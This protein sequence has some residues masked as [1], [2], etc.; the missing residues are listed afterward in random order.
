MSV[1]ARLALGYLIPQPDRRTAFAPTAVAVTSAAAAA[2]RAPLNVPPPKP[3][4]FRGRAKGV[5]NRKTI[6]KQDAA[7]KGQV[8]LLQ[9]YDRKILPKA[10][11]QA[12]PSLLTLVTTPF[13]AGT[14]VVARSDGIIEVSLRGLP[15]KAFL[16]QS[17]VKF[18][19]PYGCAFID[20][21]RPDKSVRVSLV[22]SF[23]KYQRGL[24][25]CIL[26][27][28]IPMLFKKTSAPPPAK[29]KKPVRVIGFHQPHKRTQWSPAE[30]LEVVRWLRAA[31][32]RT[33]E[34][35]TKYARSKFGK[36]PSISSVG[37]WNEAYDVPTARRRPGRTLQCLPF[38][39][40]LFRRIYLLRRLMQAAVSR[41][42][43]LREA[44]RMKKSP[45]WINDPAVKRLKLSQ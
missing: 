29:I 40:A 14:V 11:N 1:Q 27:L 21:I 9:T 24:P 8:T 28:N 6:A 37:Q 33:L 19:T 25:T 4:G 35:A 7:V 31:K 10:N 32:S 17:V 34:S 38:R 30:R 26:K 15:T 41:S 23:G 44:S 42:T 13:G 22:S 36:T 20:E 2:I 18:Q 5:L 3:A 45:K 39:A 43:V 12:L 16:H